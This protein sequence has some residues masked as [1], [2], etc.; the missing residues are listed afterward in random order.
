MPTPTP[1]PKAEF[2]G[3]QHLPQGTAVGTQYDSSSDLYSAYSR[4]GS[5]PSRL[6]PLPANLRQEPQA[7]RTLLPQNFIVPV[8]VVTNPQA[9]YK[10]FRLFIRLR[11]RLSHV[12]RAKDPTPPTPL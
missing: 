2:E 12:L 6:F 11:H 8:A 3:R 1:P 10:H 4:R 9:T 7:R 5:S